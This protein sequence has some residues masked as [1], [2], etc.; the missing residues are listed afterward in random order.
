M[1]LFQITTDSAG[2]WL[3]NYENIEAAEIA[4]IEADSQYAHGNHVNVSVKEFADIV[5]QGVT[6][7]GDFFFNKNGTGGTIEA[8]PGIDISEFNVSVYRPC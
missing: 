6:K 2:Q 3:G 8:T 1:K 4:G 7:Q 5:T